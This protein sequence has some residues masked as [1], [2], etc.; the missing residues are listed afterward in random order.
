MEESRET[1]ILHVLPQDIE[2]MSFQII[3]E[4]LRQAGRTIP[5]DRKH[6]LLRVIHTTADFEYFDTMAFSEG[7]LERA[8]DALRRGAHIVTDTTMAMSGI[9]KRKLAE[10]GGE[11]H[12]YIA[13]PDVAETAKHCGTTRSAAAVDKAVSEAE[14]SGGPTIFAVGNAPTALL[15]LEEKIL[16][17]YRPEL[18]IAVPVGF[19]NVITAKERIMRTGVPYICNRGRKGGSGV[20]AAICNAILYRITV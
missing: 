18:V 1:G 17:G 3:E 5:E 20:A 11:A 6:V 10:L 7:A 16:Q 9:N 2:K 8:E 13:D 15:A 12:C 19:V 4:E 14:K